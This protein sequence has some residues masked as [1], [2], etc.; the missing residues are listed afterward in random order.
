[1]KKHVM[2]L[3]ECLKRWRTAYVSSG[4]DGLLDERRIKGS[5]VRKPSEE[6]TTE[7]QLTRS[8]AQRSV[9]DNGTC[10]CRQLQRLIQLLYLGHSL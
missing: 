10:G 7:K 4:E 9:W 1:M 2:R 8:L 5:T 3:N 6:L